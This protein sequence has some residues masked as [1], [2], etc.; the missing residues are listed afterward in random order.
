MCRRA[1]HLAEVGN[2]LITSY[3][4]TTR[5]QCG[6]VSALVLK[7]NWRDLWCTMAASGYEECPP[8][9]TTWHIIPPDYVHLEDEY[10]YSPD[11]T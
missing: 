4:S 7:K 11:K 5:C 9:D 10:R 2:V 1:V 6:S 3:L 8:Y